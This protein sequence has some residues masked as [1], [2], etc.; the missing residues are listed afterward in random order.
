MQIRHFTKPVSLTEQWHGFTGAQT[1]LG[2]GYWGLAALDY[3]GCDTIPAKLVTN[4]LLYSA[5]MAAGMA[6][7][8]VTGKIY[9][10]ARRPS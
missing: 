7:A 6:V 10:V 2:I 8:W 5:L 1:V 4:W 9:R 3:R